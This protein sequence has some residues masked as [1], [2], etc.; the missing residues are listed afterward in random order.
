MRFRVLFRSTL[1]LV[2]IALLLFFVVPPARYLFKMTNQSPY[3]S[4]W[5]GLVDVR[6]QLGRDN[7]AHR[8]ET[9]MRKV[10]DDTNHSLSQWESP[11]GRFWVPAGPPA[12]LAYLLAQQQSDIYGDEKAGV[13][14]GDVVID[15]GA[16][17][18]VF[19]RKALSRGARVVVAVEPAPQAAEC[20]RRNFSNEIKSGT[21]IMCEKAIWDKPDMTLKFYLNGNEDAADSLIWQNKQ[22]AAIEVKTTTIDAIATEYHLNRIDFIKADIKGAAASMLH[23]STNTLARNHPRMAISTEEGHDHPAEVAALV[24]RISNSYRTVCGPCITVSGN[25]FTDVLFFQ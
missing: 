1:W 12:V 4:K 13:H 11:D 9:T 18:G 21:V 2:A 16:H 17:V 10:G 23:G 3:C 22:A 5:K 25:I 20:L 24:T 15:C 19:V 14:S 7:A 8:I 6:V